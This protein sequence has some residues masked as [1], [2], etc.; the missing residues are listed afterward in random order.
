MGNTSFG[1]L[2]SGYDSYSEVNPAHLSY[3][4]SLAK[5]LGLDGIEIMPESVS[6]SRRSCAATFRVLDLNTDETKKVCIC[7]NGTFHITVDGE[8]IDFK[9]SK[10]P[11]LPNCLQQ[12]FRVEA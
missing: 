3:C 6:F 10:Y 12:V 8:A 1:I 9:S 11:Q 2:G 7:K 5:A 4:N